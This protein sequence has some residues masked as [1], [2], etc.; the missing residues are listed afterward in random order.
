MA[1][2]FYNPLQD[3]IDCAEKIAPNIECIVQ[4]DPTM[5]EG[6]NKAPYGETCFD[7][8]NTIISI[9]GNIPISISLEILAHELAHVIAG[10]ADEHGDKWESAFQAILEEYNKAAG[11]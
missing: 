2:Q 9:N 6:E 4:F 8:E 10:E 7:E 3:I 1:V 11:L 5:G